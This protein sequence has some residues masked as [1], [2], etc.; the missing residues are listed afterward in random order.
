M[1]KAVRKP[2]FI[3]DR[4]PV[5]G[6]RGA[7]FITLHTTQGLGTIESYARF[8]RNTPD[9][10]GS[11]FMVERTGRAGLYV[12]NLND[13]TYHVAHNNSRMIGIEQVGF[14]ETSEKDWLRKYR[15]QLFMTAWICAWVGQR[16]G[17]VAIVAGNKKRVLTHSTGVVEHSMVPSNT[18]WDCGPGYP[19]DFVVKYMARWMKSGGPTI[20]T[21]AYIKTGHRPVGSK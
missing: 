9:G 11:S 3:E 10:L 7:K 8:F 6:S 12:H 16:E 20:A 14:A 2:P 18:H 13:L 5:H 4:V 19:L 15:R 21:R 17:I 1:A